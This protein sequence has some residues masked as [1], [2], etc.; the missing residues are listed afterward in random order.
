MIRF[1]ETGKAIARFRTFQNQKFE[2]VINVPESPVY[3]LTADDELKLKTKNGVP[4]TLA[5]GENGSLIVTVEIPDKDIV[6]G[7]NFFD[8]DAVELFI[9]CTPFRH[10]GAEKIQNTQTDLRVKQFAFDPNGRI[11]GGN[12]VTRVQEPGGTTV[13]ITKNE[14]S[15]KC[16]VT[17]PNDEIRPV[18]GN[19]LGFNL[20]LCRNDGGKSLGKDV[21]SGKESYL[22][23][24]HY[25]LIRL[26]GQLAGN[27]KL[28]QTAS[29]RFSLPEEPKWGPKSRRGSFTAA[30]AG[31]MLPSGRYLLRF[32]AR[33]RK[34]VQLNP[35]RSNDKSYLPQEDS[36]TCYTL[37]YQLKKDQKWAGIYFQ[38]LA[39]RPDTD[40]WG[41][42]KDVELIR[43]DGAAPAVD[44][45]SSGAVF[46]IDLQVDKDICGLAPDGGSKDLSIAK[47]TWKKDKADCRLQISGNSGKKWEEKWAQFIPAEDCIVEINLMSSSMKDYDVAYDNIRIEGASIKNG[48]FE[49][50]DS[51]GNLQ[52]WRGMGKK[53]VL[54]NT[55]A[56]DG[57]NCVEVSHNNRAYQ[58]IK[59]KK[60]QPVKITFMVRDAKR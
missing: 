2:K 44:V 6:C 21:F 1:R 54:K 9:D 34:I 14:K 26:P 11:Y 30:V 59:C 49:L 17:L 16:V 43:Q 58:V 20:E 60:G 10:I 29:G 4:F 27:I 5:A 37:T 41:E 22:N 40:A 48:S 36:W 50:V 31:G 12:L 45:S 15:W 47:A 46:R 19:V 25:A 23:R 38:V 55:D 42:I 18:E 32:A 24:Q 53:Y 28:K 3:T 56:A 13:K 57:K 35:A 51:N 52:N 8:G 39:A 33:G 7:K